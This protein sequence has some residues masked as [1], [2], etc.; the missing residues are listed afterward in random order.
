MWGKE[1]REP[2]SCQNSDALGGQM[3]EDCPMLSTRPLVGVWLW[4]AMD[5]QLGRGWT[6]GSPRY[7][8]LSLQHPTLDTTEELRT[9][10][11]PGQLS[12]LWGPRE[13]RAGGESA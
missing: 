13:E 2:A 6:S 4:K 10:E 8:V 12:Q 1:G 9:N 11:G 5:P 7:Q 3:R